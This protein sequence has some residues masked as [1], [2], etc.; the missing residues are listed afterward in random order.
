M[1]TSSHAHSSSAGTLRQSISTA[2]TLIEVPECR[3]VLIVDDE[4]ENLVVLEALL[5]D[6]GYVVL[7]AENGDEA[8]A[9]FEQHP[10][11]DMVISDQRM[12][13]MSGVELLSKIAASHPDTMRV[14]L[15]AYSDVEPIVSA[16]NEGSVYRFLLKPWSDVELRA[17]VEEG[18]TLRTQQ[19][20]LQRLV[21]ALSSQHSR[22]VRTLADLSKTHDQQLAAE[23]L[24]TLG[25]LT[26]GITHD[27]NNHLAL[28]QGVLFEL[29][30]QNPSYELRAALSDAQ[31]HVAS[32]VQLMREVN[33]FARSEERFA[34]PEKQ[35]TVEFLAEMLKLFQLEAVTRTP[36]IR[37]DVAPNA[38][39]VY[40]ERA[41]LQQA[42]LAIL[43]NATSAHATHI[44]V[45]V[46]ARE[47]QI[48]FSVTDDGS[49][50]DE[51]TLAKALDP[52]FS[53]TNPPGLG[54]GLG[55]AKLVAQAHGG[56]LTLMSERGSGTT[57][58]L[59]VKSGPSWTAIPTATEER[60]HV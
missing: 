5:E 48:E 43:R 52:F 58:T 10:D 13:R 36:V 29:E 60:H 30:S 49:G 38:D 23:R 51:N 22:L 32:L 8:L 16:V 3:T 37:V 31:E 44:A 50:M 15:T 54:I 41:R 9:H 21:D 42:L 53:G 11:I 56:D 40:A 59:S 24:G 25:R 6:E 14:V 4:F 19:Q 1:L 12:P 18:L 20:T 17:T 46:T 28:I 45:K 35:T 7:S 33:S 2:S 27:V 34:T 55:I 26:S 39:T 47:E 57:V